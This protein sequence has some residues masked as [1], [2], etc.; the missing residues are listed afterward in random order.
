MQFAAGSPV[1][2]NNSKYK[3][4]Q[5]NSQRRENIVKAYGESKLNAGQQK[6]VYGRSPLLVLS[7]YIITS[8][9]KKQNRVEPKRRK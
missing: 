6:C 9:V 5:S 7:G 2:A 8:S 3:P 1:S 4:G